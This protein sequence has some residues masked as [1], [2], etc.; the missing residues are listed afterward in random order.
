[1]RGD[2]ES[3]KMDKIRMGKSAAVGAATIYYGGKGGSGKRI[4]M[5]MESPYYKFTL[6]IR[7]TQGG[8]GYPTRMMCDFTK[9]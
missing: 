7:D 1:M 2:I 6:N 4:N 3:Y 9:K 5:E 8:D